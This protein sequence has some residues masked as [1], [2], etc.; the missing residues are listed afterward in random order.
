MVAGAV[1]S[2]GWLVRMVGLWLEIE[3]HYHKVSSGA[4]CERQASTE[5]PKLSLSDEEARVVL[6]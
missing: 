5:T 1:M 2:A 6:H 4:D 3:G